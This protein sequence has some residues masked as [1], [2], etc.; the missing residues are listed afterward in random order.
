MAHLGLRTLTVLRFVDAGGGERALQYTGDPGRV[1]LDPRWY[2]AAF[3]FVGL[4]FDHI[5][6]G[7]DHLLFLLCLVIPFRRLRGLVTLVTSFTVGHSITLIA[8]ASGIAPDTLWFPALVETLIALSIVYMA[9]ENI[10]GTKL[11]RRW[12]MAFGFGL[13]HGFGFSFLL[14]ER[15]QFAGPQLLTALVSFNVG[16]EL[17]QLFVIVL[18]L[19]VLRLLFTRVVEERIG[20]IIL[21]ALLAHTAWH[22]MT[23]RGGELLQYDFTVPIFDT[24]FAATLMRWLMLLLIVGGLAWLLKLAF[25]RFPRTG[26]RGSRRRGCEAG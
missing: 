14:A 3:Q 18:A 9:L 11:Q 20:T 5:L 23:E 1:R 26:H 25:E 12:V 4:G 19:P 2:H 6:D 10:V 21:S 17:G 13:V 7:I 15:L 16:V 22:W 8:S 24:S